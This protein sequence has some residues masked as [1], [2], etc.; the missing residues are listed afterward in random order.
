M[1]CKSENSLPVSGNTLDD[2]PMFLLCTAAE[3]TTS[4]AQAQ[5]E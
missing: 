4:V 1:R 3:W 5:G 2:A